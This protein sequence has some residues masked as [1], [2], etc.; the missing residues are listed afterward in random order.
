MS[1]AMN[2]QI[3]KIQIGTRTRQNLGDIDGLA[4]SIDRVGLL[5]PVVMSPDG[6]LVAGHRRIEACRRLGWETIDVVVVGHLTD[7]LNLLI[8]ERDE[9]ICRKDFTPSEMK[10]M[11]DRLK[12]LAEAEA[13]D[14]QRASGGDKTAGQSGS[15][16]MALPARQAREDVAEAVGT[17]ATTLRRVQEV[18]DTAGDESLPASVREIAREEIKVMDDTGHVAGSHQRMLEAKWEHTGG[19]RESVSPRQRVRDR[20]KDPALGL[21]DTMMYFD[22]QVKAL[23]SVRL[24]ET[25]SAERAAPWLKQIAAHRSAMNKLAKQIKELIQ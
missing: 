1:N 3:D 9:N 2:I 23:D 21:D 16:Q 22:H 11:A 7:A 5:Q 20:K 8:A 24:P 17:S 6:R 10:A 12:P 14:R 19:P 13:K 18:H 25:V 4:A 15:G